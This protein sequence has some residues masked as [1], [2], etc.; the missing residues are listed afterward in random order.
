MT[1]WRAHAAHGDW[2]LIR[3]AS[4]E[5]E[6]L[7]SLYEVLRETVPK[8]QRRDGMELG[9]D[10][11]LPHEIDGDTK[12]KQAALL[13]NDL[14]WL[15]E[16]EPDWK[17]EATNYAQTVLEELGVSRRPAD[18]AKYLSR[19]WHA[20][21]VLDLLSAFQF[22]ISA[23]AV[24]DEGEDD[25]VDTPWVHDRMNEAGAL[26]FAIGRHAQA[27]WGKPY[28]VVAHGRELQVQMRREISV[29]G[30][31]AR[32]A[33]KQLARDAL[34]KIALAPDTL[35]KWIILG[36][37]ERINFLKKLASDFDR[38]R[39]EDERR[40]HQGVKPKL[41]GSDW[42]DEELSGWRRAGDLERAIK[43]IDISDGCGEKA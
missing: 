16:A 5:E 2:Q 12:L 4:L 17:A 32:K 28:E 8:V 36:D 43:N 11:A 39:P 34:R 10:Y 40:F 15:F 41:Y 27:A 13:F 42:F 21:R 30:G 31:E 7:P 24:G 33:R 38:K 23:T 14:R 29:K 35:R 18:H 19:E 1:D 25:Q 9:E 22:T 20:Q 6:E 37:R 3:L 26:A